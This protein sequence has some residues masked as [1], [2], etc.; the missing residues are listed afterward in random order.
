MRNGA[1][2]LTVTEAGEAE[3]LRRIV[4]RLGEAE[5][6]MLGP[7]DDCAV[8]RFS[9][10]A[11]V[12]TDTMIE[13]P[14]FRLAWHSGF[15]LGWKLAATN[16][17]DVAAMGAAPTAL[18][19]AF[20][21][22]GETPVALL[23]EIARGLDAA[24]RELAPGCGV[25]G[26]DL[27]RAPALTASVTALGELDG[28]PPVLRSGAR[29]GDA[30]AYAGQLGLA[31]LGLSLLFAE[32]ADPDGVAHADGL[33]G[34]RTR[35]PA[36]LAAQLAPEP[37]IHLGMRAARAGATA[38]LDVSD[39]LTLDAARIGRASSVLLDLD[40]LAL[41]AAF[42]EQNG[43]SVP[44]DAMLYGGEDHG[45]L[46]TFPADAALPEGFS[47]I[48]TVRDGAAQDVA[49]QDG[50]AQDGAAPSGSATELLLAGEPCEVRGWDP[51]TV[52]LPGG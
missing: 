51:F 42:G 18:T 30:V 14:D 50:A 9:G 15:E 38:M 27:A 12:T 23:E 33:T 47:R 44:L 52:R 46:A 2:E 3:V 26:G 4:A 48:G 13:G 5:R 24:C 31:G 49:A 40:P 10:D 8:L 21:C 35:H 19:V 20:A 29:A 17:S 43:E 22:P 7:G 41:H 11:V 6:A 1:D 45:L 28:Y 39:G 34:I 16:L 25:I 36:A 32:S 37:P